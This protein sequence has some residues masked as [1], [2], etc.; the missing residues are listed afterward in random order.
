MRR[1]NQFF[2]YYAQLFKEQSDIKISDIRYKNILY[3]YELAL[4]Y[5]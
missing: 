1:H 5:S 3:I 4:S 2:A